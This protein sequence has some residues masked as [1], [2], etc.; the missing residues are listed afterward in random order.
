MF[1]FPLFQK[2]YGS[3]QSHAVT[4]TPKHVTR[5]AD[6]LDL[7]TAATRDMRLDMTSPS[8][9]D[10]DDYVTSAAAFMGLKAPDKEVG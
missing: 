3:P 9:S 4:R 6:D 10:C 7:C 8:T 5:S 2:L 1:D